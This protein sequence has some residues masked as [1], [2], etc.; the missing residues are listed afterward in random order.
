[1][2]KYTFFV[3]ILVGAIAN[4]SFG[5]SDGLSGGSDRKEEKPNTVVTI[6]IFGA[7]HNKVEIIDRSLN[8]HVY[9]LVSGHG[10]PDSGALGKDADKCLC[11][12]EYAYDVTLRLAKNLMQHGALVYMITRDSNDGIRDSKHLPCDKDEVCWPKQNMP[13]NQKARLKQR[14]SAINSLYAENRK[15]GYSKQRLLV[16]HIDSRSESQRTDMF[17]Y[18]HPNSTKGR[19]LVSNLRNTIE[20]KYEINQ[21]GRGYSGK[22]S[23]RNLFMLRESAPVAGYVELGNLQ[24]SMDQRRFLLADNR[25]AVANWLAEGLMSER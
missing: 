22:V 25:Q 7:G 15:K 5:A 12:D 2:V 18:H 21:R 8:N 4:Q 1:M 19:S 20:K 17:F 24:N 13:L 10:G 9:Y 16:L 23:G 14:V 3:S 11:E 6:P